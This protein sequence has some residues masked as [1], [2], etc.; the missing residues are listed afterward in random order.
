LAWTLARRHILQLQQR[1][2]IATAM[3]VA[4]GGASAPE[5]LAPQGKRRKP[6]RMIEHLR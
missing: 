5:A 6:G 2:H 1:E 3:Q 4:G